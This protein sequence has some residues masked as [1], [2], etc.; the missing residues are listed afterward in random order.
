M[1]TPRR[2]VEGARLSY[3]ASLIT[4]GRHKFYSLTLPS[5]VLARTCFVST[6]SEAPNEG[7][8]R[9]LDKEKAQKIADYID[10]ENGTI[11]TAIILSAQSESRFEYS[12]KNKTIDFNDI[13]K[14]FLILDGQHRVYGFSLAETSVRI[15]V[16][17]Y[18]SLT[19]KDETR[20]FIDINTK[21]R[22][23]P[24]EL[25]LDIKALAEY[26]NESEG[27]L[28]AIYNNFKASALHGKLSS[29]EK[30]KDKIT[31]VTFNAAVKPLGVI[32]GDKEAEDVYKILNDYLKAIQIGFKQKGIE[33]KI[34]NPYVFRAIMSIFPDVA[35]KVKDRYPEYT[36]D[37]FYHSLAYF[38]ENI[39]VAKI[40][41]KHQGHKELTDHL[42]SSLRKDF[43]L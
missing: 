3:T 17:I 40:S 13:S 9:T 37:N 4:Q 33:N 26:E 30:A 41:K 11:P 22:P 6:R 34:V 19:R 12:S 43:T 32:F 18:N 2:K 39:S 10:K 8:Q 42:L 23:V 36:M 38:F 5:E 16:I 28:R 25:L 15:P 1:P 14:A 29:S 27:Y 31:R 21:Q 24:N 35:G 20:L 7:F